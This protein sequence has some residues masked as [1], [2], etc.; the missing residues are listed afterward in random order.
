MLF[1]TN[2]DAYADISQATAGVV[3]V[4]QYFQPKDNVPGKWPVWPGKLAGLVQVVSFR[5]NLTDMN[6]GRLDKEIVA[7]LKTAPDYSMTTVWHEANRPDLNLSPSEF[8]AA[9]ARLKLLAHQANPTLTT[10]Q[11]FETYRV[12]YGQDLRPWV[13]HGQHWYG[14]DGYQDATKTPTEVFGQTKTYITDVAQYARILITET[15]SHSDMTNWFPGAMQYAVAEGLHGFMPFFNTPT[16]GL[17]WAPSLAGQMQAI[18]R[19][20]ASLS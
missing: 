10:G 5:P 12:E 17:K 11:I 13:V 19:Q 9:S 16:G 15:N 7:F 3:A 6:A 18:A 2:Q 1:G 14:M 4:R 8:R 20:A